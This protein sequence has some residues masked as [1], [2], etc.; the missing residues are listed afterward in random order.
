MEGSESTRIT[1]LQNILVELGY[2]KSDL[3]SGVYDAHTIS[4]IYDFQ[5]KAS[6]LVSEKDIGAGVYG[7]KTRKE[8]EKLY[9]VYNK[10][11]QEKEN[12]EAQ[13]APLRETSFSQAEKHVSSLEKPEFGEISPRV[14][15]LQKTL[16]KLGYFPHKD[17]AIFG[18]KTQNALLEYQS[19]KELISTPSDLGAGTF[20]P[21]TR[22][23]FT[24]D[25]A[26]I[27]FREILE[28]E[29][30]TEQYKKYYESENIISSEE[31]PK[32]SLS[33]ISTK[34]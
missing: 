27:Y 10:E 8:L 16:E 34:I 28:K 13:I 3:V 4:A 24:K 26:E 6:I 25:L 19:K 30:L 15:E 11:K 5:I 29:K 7:P 21:Q 20:G 31:T 18:V 17:T 14:R 23:Q 2:L 22:A 33:D 9:T 12:F 32:V 1:E